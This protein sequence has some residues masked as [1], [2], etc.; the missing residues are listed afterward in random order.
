MTDIKS[1]PVIL[2]DGSSYL[3]R[4]YHALPPLTN[5]KGQPTGAVYGVTNMIRK[6]LS[7]YEPERIAV[8]FDSKVKTFRHELYQEYKANRASMPE[9]L[10]TQIKPLH[11]LIKA[12]GIPLIIV[13]GVEADDVIGTLASQA[14][15]DGYEVLIST[16]DK[17]MTQLVNGQVTLINTMTNTV[18]DHEGVVKKYGLRP[19]QM[20]DYLTLVGDTSDNIPG[21][22]SVGPKT[23]QKWLLQYD[24]LDAI[25]ADA[26]NISGKVGENF[27]QALPHI[28]LSKQ[29]VTIK[30]DV[31]L[32]VKLK[33][34]H[35][36]QQN[37][38]L[39]RDLYQQLEFKAL[40]T[41]LEH[42]PSSKSSSY[43]TLLTEAQLNEWVRKLEKAP[44]IAFDTETN[45]LNDIV[46][47][48]VGISMSVQPGE[49]V[50]IP[51]AHDYPHAPKQLDRQT[52]LEALVPI[53]NDEK[54]NIIGQN[55]KYDLNVLGNYSYTI[56]AHLY[57]TML[58]SYVLSGGVGRHNMDSLALNYLGKS[59][60]TFE[61]V[62]G[63]GKKQI[64]FNKVEIDKATEYAAEDADI[65][66]QLHNTLWSKLIA[67]PAVAK[68]FKNIEMP[69]VRVLMRMERY[70][71]L[72]DSDLLKEDLRPWPNALNN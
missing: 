68:V 72:I 27:R 31:P 24:N 59:T 11:D 44:V 65:T 7:D 57:D 38:D 66:L 69:L 1:K 42:P 56:L 33:D 4:A 19:D 15:H 71:V 45:S 41:K 26:N 28:P 16:G 58:E 8:V 54:K 34:L 29:L 47:E 43:K 5:S 39:M 10:Q 22:P 12:M 53:L 21:V 17:D 51:L 18:L 2:I 32:S 52:V 63:K 36:T 30:C 3:F 40:L 14:K 61:E 13:D 9:E 50:Y 55:I 48:L 64:T 6:L 23:A 62:A 46:A 35:L 37:I 20:I 25:I 49:A 60:I 67:V 70:G